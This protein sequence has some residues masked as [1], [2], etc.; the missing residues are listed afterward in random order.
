[1]NYEN[2]LVETRG[3]V[4]IVTLNRPKALNALSPALMRELSDALSSVDDIPDFDQATLDEF[5]RRSEKVANGTAMATP[6]DIV[7]K[8]VR[9]RVER[10][11][12]SRRDG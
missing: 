2:I 3:Q 4:G 5:R 6:W 12:V 8:R 11:Y 10:R 1:M 7:R 9:E